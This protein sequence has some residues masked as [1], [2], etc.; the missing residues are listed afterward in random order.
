MDL[1]SS[2]QG[3]VGLTKYDPSWKGYKVK[4]RYVLNKGQLT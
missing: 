1:I 3:R 4:V 2:I